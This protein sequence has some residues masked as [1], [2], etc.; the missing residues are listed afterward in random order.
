[1]KKTLLIKALFVLIITFFYSNLYSQKDWKAE[2]KKDI[3]KV[4]NGKF[5]VEEFALLK[6]DEVTSYQIKTSASGPTDIISRDNFVGYYSSLSM[7]FLYQMF[8]QSGI[9]ITNI[10]MKDLDELIGDPDI[11]IHFEMTKNGMQIQ[12]MSGEEKNNITM[13]WE[14]LL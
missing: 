10:D 7:V 6:L 11:T 1:M 14:D 4:D 3:V 13:L 8:A 12:I 5:Q 9:D 2:I